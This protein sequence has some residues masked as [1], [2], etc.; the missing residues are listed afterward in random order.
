MRLEMKKRFMLLYTNFRRRKYGEPPHYLQSSIFKPI[1]N[2][3]I[4]F[5]DESDS[6]MR[7]KRMREKLKVMLSHRFEPDGMG[8]TNLLS[9]S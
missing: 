5:T 1:H 7:Q 4:I 8:A 9:N 3:Q 6:T 2:D